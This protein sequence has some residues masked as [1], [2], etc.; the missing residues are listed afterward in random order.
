MGTLDFVEEL[1]QLDPFSEGEGTFR[2]AKYPFDAGARM[3]R[4][5]AKA[6]TVSSYTA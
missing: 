4:S 6:G 5:T 2:R 1:R 3:T